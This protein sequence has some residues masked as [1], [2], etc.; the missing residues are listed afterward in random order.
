MI[1]SFS[2]QT[3]AVYITQAFVPT[4]ILVRKP[5]L[6]VQVQFKFSFGAGD[7]VD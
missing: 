2:S 4:V 1:L 3:T 6:P 5:I 7:V